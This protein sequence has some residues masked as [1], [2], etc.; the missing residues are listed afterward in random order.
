MSKMTPTPSIHSCNGS[1]T[2]NRIAGH[3][4]GWLAAP[5]AVE[6]QKSMA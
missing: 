4:I 1:P 6:L 5:V 2:P 3:C